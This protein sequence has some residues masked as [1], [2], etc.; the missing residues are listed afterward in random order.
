LAGYGRALRTAFRRLRRGGITRSADIQIPDSAELAEVLRLFDLFREATCRFYDEE[1]LLTEAA[2]AVGEGK[3]GPSADLGSLVVVPP[4]AQS[5][6]A[7]ALLRALDAPG[8][9][10]KNEGDGP[11]STRMILA[12]DPA[13]E[14]REVVREV[15]F[16][17]E[18][19]VAIHE[20][21][22]FHGADTAY[23]GL[24]REAFGAAGVPA[25]ILPGIPL[26]SSA[27]GRA[28]LA[29]LNLPVEGY[30][31]RRMMDFFAMRPLKEWVPAGTDRARNNQSAWDR[32]SRAAGITRGI[33]RWRGGLLTHVTDLDRQLAHDPRIT[34]SES[35]TRRVTFERDKT[36]ELQS[37]VSALVGYLE[38]LEVKQ[39]AKEFITRFL[40]V[41]EAFMAKEAE[42][43]EDVLREIDQLGTVDAVGGSFDL[44][45]FHEALRANLESGILKEGRSRLGE[46]V[47][48]ADYRMAAGLN[49]R[50]V[51]LCGAYEDALPAGAGAEPLLDDRT[52]SRLRA[53]HPF[54]EDTDVRIERGREAADR[55]IASASGGILIWSCPVY[56]PGATRDFYPSPMMVRGANALDPGIG[57][58][59][60]LRG[61]SSQP[62]LLR[63]PSPLAS[64][65]HGI[66]TSP[67]EVTLRDAVTLRRS[68][69][70]IE[71]SHRLA[72]SVQ[73]LRSR[74]SSSFTEWDG[75]LSAL[76][77]ANW[78]A[79][80]SPVGPTTLETYATCGYRYFAR[81][82]LRLN[83]VEEPEEREM[84]D[85]A[86]RGTLVHRVLERFFQEMKTVG[87][88]APFEKWGQAD[89][90]TLATI[91][92]E[93]MEAS[94][95]RGLTGR[96][97]FS[98]R[99]SQLLRADL[100]RFL[101]IDEEFR[102]STGAVPAEFEADLPGETVG[103]V[104]LCGKVDRI[105]RTPDGQRAWIIDYKT[106]STREFTKITV[107]PLRGGT[108]LQL[109]AYLSAA[110]DAT[111][112][113]ALYWFI[114]HKGGFDQIEF[115][116]TP[117]NVRRFEE[118]VAAIVEGVRAGA[119]PAF[120]G[121][122]DEF[123]GG[124]DNCGFCEFNRVCS[125]RR[126]YEYATKSN[127][128][129]M[130]AWRAVAGV[131]S[132]E[133]DVGDIDE[134]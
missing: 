10:Q 14:A 66:A 52:W 124:W 61:L 75:N 8:P 102:A 121:N 36:A 129:G 37:V 128:P 17:M 101:D 119:F 60:R 76:S 15:I 22:V 120:S 90:Q 114:T 94:K 99:E 123:R 115:E 1:D 85:P 91:L 105:D 51:V 38:P 13:S 25:V 62:W 88:P 112:A 45:S 2:A 74:R 109:P 92:D 106:G 80:R 126:E 98:G 3:S 59:T 83:A 130:S 131:A 132:P 78:L 116:N 43:Y 34:E 32:V 55:A 68:G 16:A 6:G 12:P 42:G 95:A 108:K 35:Q 67:A 23:A 79:V 41:V 63:S 40:S 77:P 28:V 133:G 30:Q 117:E 5:A 86:H 111:E 84:M 20:V 33:A 113:A 70:A 49:F 7:D 104:T 125:R 9:V 54:V 18:N 57:T 110:R 89:K 50:H 96:E 127:D 58:A 72:R 64:M 4:G 48:V 27:M 56:E 46:G 19:G 31:R 21:A 73:M 122:V 103:G 97:I 107:D 39:H 134:S 87:R 100:M 11:G 82:I 81:S 65:L 44:K 24:L 69:K 93:E 118:T 71:A 29:L 53:T 47:L 26:A